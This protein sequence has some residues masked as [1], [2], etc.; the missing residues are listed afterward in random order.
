M[1]MIINKVIYIYI[2]LIVLSWIIK[3][4]GALLFSSWLSFTGIP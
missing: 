1:F 2:Y 3:L 4:V